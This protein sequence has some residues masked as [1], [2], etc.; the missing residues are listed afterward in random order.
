MDEESSGMVPDYT[1]SR[2]RLST[3]LGH[4]IDYIWKASKLNE[5]I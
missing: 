5:G 2:I 4:G 3:A 1:K